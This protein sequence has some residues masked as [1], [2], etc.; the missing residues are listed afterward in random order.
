MHPIVIS[1][2][3]A[4]SG[5]PDIQE[6]KKIG[7]GKIL[8]EAKSATAANRLVDNPAF[9]KPNLKAFIPAFR[10]LREGVIQDVPTELQLDYIR[11]NI[12]FPGIKILEIFR[13]NRRIT[14]NNKSEYVP[15]RIHRIKFAG[16]VLPRV[17]FLFKTRHEVRPFIPKS[18][19][20]FKCYRAGHVAKVCKGSPRCLYCGNNVHNEE[21][22]C[23]GA[24]VDVFCINCKG[25]HLSTS[26]ECPVVSRQD[27]I[28]KLA[29]IENISIADARRIIGDQSGSSSRYANILNS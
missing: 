11:R 12:K 8:I 18:R 17:V 4:K 5:I 23:K 21:E 7:R 24:E 29:A 27:N 10:V 6:I 26:K 20:C 22:P 3:V 1:S 28:I 15:S 2:I 13:F 16:Q 9:T 19:I 25:S 14:I